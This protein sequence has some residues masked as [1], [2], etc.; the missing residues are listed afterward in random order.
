MRG[1]GLLGDQLTAIAVTS[2]T[3]DDHIIQAAD[4]FEYEMRI[5]H[6]ELLSSRI[7]GFLPFNSSNPKVEIFFVII[8]VHTY[9]R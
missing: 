5:A 1:E 2:W 9:V 7:E 4:F 8:L 6:G 3:L